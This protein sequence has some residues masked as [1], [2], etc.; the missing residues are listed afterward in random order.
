MLYRVRGYATMLQVVL[1][2]WVVCDNDI[3]RIKC[4]VNTHLKLFVNCNGYLYSQV[5][6]TAESYDSK[7]WYIDNYLSQLKP[8]L[9][10]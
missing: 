1:F 2:C 3:D 4:K 9:Q 8:Q 7:N 5:P 10:E 6:L